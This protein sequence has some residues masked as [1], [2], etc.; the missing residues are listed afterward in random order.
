MTVGAVI[1]ESVRDG[2]LR[3]TLRNPTRR[4]AVSPSMFAW[5][6]QRCAELRGEVVIVTGAGSDGFCSGFDLTELDARGDAG[7]PPDSSLIAATN[8]MAAADATFVAAIDGHAIGAGVELAC[9]C[10]FRIAATGARFRVPAGRLCVVYH[11]QGL[12]RMNAVFGAGLTRRLVLAGEELSAEEIHAAGGLHSL[13]QP[14]QLG[15]AV[16]ALSRQLC[17]QAPGSVRGNRA[18][19][20]ALDHSPLPPDLLEAH[21]RRRAEVYASEDHAEAKA[22]V[23]ERRSPTWKDR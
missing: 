3:W 18:L 6:E 15:S 5:I 8:S 21:E 14:E 23:R 13:V 1:E 9:I 2:L 16:E 4:N 10:D 22:A 19:L 7:E 20:R 12:V 17:E 11:A